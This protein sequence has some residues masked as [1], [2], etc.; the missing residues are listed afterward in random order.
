MA[1]TDPNSQGEPF[2]VQTKNGV[3]ACLVFPLCNVKN[4]GMTCIDCTRNK[5][6]QTKMSDFY[7]D[8]EKRRQEILETLSDALEKIP[9]EKLKNGTS[10]F[11][12]VDLKK[13]QVTNFALVDNMNEALK[14]IERAIEHLNMAGT[15]IADV[16]QAQVK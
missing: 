11:F 9:D 2:A 3:V 6:S 16:A 7:E 1:T 10:V 4:N 15:L 13:V 14:S 8:M 5:Y 12:S